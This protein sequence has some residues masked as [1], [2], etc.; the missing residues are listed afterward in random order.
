M[1]DVNTLNDVNLMSKNEM[2]KGI[3]LK[4]PKVSDVA[5]YSDILLH[6]YEYGE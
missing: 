4:C 1:F 2:E 3:V 5:H 6:N